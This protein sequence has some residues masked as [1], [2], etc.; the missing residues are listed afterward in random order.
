MNLYC[1]TQ[2][3]SQVWCCARWHGPCVIIALVALVVTKRLHC[4]DM[5][6]DMKVDHQPAQV[7]E[8]WHR[9]TLLHARQLCDHTMDLA[10]WTCYLVVTCFCV[11]W[12]L[13]VPILGSGSLQSCRGFGL[14]RTLVCCKGMLFI[15]S[16]TLKFLGGDGSPAGTCSALGHVG[17]SD[18]TFE[19]D[20]VLVC[21]SVTK[22]EPLGSSYEVTKNRLNQITQFQLYRSL[23]LIVLH[24]RATPFFL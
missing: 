13:Y 24:A 10:S 21:C 15:V 3:P 20:H 11:K 8:V 23:F 4:F 14:R 16:V 5:K 2:I 17:P 22:N 1:I 6:G 12:L 18:P 19:L 7:Q 9:A